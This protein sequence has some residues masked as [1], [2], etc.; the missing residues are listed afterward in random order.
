M[1]V[2]YVYQIMYVWIVYDVMVGIEIV[3]IYLI[4][5]VV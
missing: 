1:H 5:V 2:V 3:Y 4:Q